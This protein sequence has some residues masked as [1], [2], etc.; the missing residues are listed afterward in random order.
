M[1]LLLFTR[2]YLN[3][4]VLWLNLAISLHHSYHLPKFGHFCANEQN[5]KWPTRTS[6]SWCRLGPN[7]P[8][9]SDLARAEL[10][11]QA[12]LR[13][14]PVPMPSAS[15]A[16]SHWLLS[17]VL[18]RNGHKSCDPM[19]CFYKTSKLIEQP[20]RGTARLTAKTVCL[21]PSDYQTLPIHCSTKV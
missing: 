4:V 12:R 16:A 14:Q 10:R 18:A 11:H 21:Q 9:L 8:P 6:P 13:L 19:R 7:E 3:C 15:L 2:H 17:L 1:K 20:L 5:A